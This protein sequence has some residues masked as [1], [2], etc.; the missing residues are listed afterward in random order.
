MN[1]KQAP[2]SSDTM[3]FSLTALIIQAS[4]L[5]VCLFSWWWT[6]SNLQQI[7]KFP[8]R[9]EGILA[10]HSAGRYYLPLFMVVGILISPAVFIL[11]SGIRDKETSNGS[12]LTDE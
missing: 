11:R 3:S 2:A 10:I 6:E 9:A 12:D 8:S 5:V 4:L 7:V 1:K